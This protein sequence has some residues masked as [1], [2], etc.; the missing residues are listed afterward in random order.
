MIAVAACTSREK[1]VVDSAGGEVSPALTD[2]NVHDYDLDMDKMR[3]WVASMKAL[4][5][6]AK[7]DS[8][9][10]AAITLNGNETMTQSIAKLEGNSKV[11]DILRHAGITARDYVMTMTAYL[12]AAM[13]DA[14]ARAVPP[15]KAPEGVNPK[16]VE[17]IRTHHDELV[18]LLK[19]DESA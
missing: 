4:M 19:D 16:N 9:L 13:V 14:A 18:E 8:S 15:G 5:T 6:A 11:T 10:A 17:F 7:Q 2:V 3:K 12:Q 1:V